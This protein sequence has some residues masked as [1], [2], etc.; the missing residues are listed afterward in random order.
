MT[1]QE[2]RIILLFHRAA[3]AKAAFDHAEAEYDKA[4]VAKEEAGTR[5]KTAK[6]TMEAIRN[7]LLVEAFGEARD[8]WDF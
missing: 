6:S 3:S 8:F 5:Y 2:E 1:E 7:E 4:R